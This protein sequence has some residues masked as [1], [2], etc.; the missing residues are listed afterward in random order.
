MLPLRTILHPTDFSAP[1]RQAF[2]L[3]WSLARDHGAKLIVL[4]VAPPLVVYG[5]F[6]AITRTEMELDH[7][8][9]ELGEIRGPDASVP[10]EHC[11]EEGEASSHILHIAK[12]K[13]CD[14]I[15]MGTHGRTGLSRW[16]L[17][18]V[19]EHVMRRAPCPVL[20]VKAVEKAKQRVS[21]EAAATAGKVPFGW[22]I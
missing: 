2:Q 5:E 21:A 9:K 16:L 3:A 22:T 13:A 4:H 14:L 7:L 18:S 19:A 17:G 10:L 15:V 8:R 12:E 6:G 11:L 20:T 1:S